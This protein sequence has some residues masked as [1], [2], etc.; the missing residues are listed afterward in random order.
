MAAFD[1]PNQN[2]RISPT[3][4]YQQQNYANALSTLTRGLGGATGVSPRPLTEKQQQQLVEQQNKRNAAQAVINDSALLEKVNKLQSLPA[5]EA[6]STLQDIRR[7][8]I[9]RISEATGVDSSELY[10]AMLGPIQ[11]QVNSRYRAVA[12]DRGSLSSIVAGARMGINEM[13]GAFRALSKN[14]E[15]A[16]AIGREVHQENEA[17]RESSPYWQDQMLRDQAGELVTFTGDT[18]SVTSNIARMLP[19]MAGQIGGTVAGAVTGG[20]VGG[21]V[22][23]FVGGTAA[24]STLGAI[25]GSQEFINRV[26]NDPRLT[27]EQKAEAIRTKRIPSAV[28]AGVFNA[29]PIN[30]NPVSQGLLR[31]ASGNIIGR[32][33]NRL[34]QNVGGRIVGNT[35]L[36]GA[37]LSLANAG[38]VLSRN[39]I[40]EQATGIDTPL[41]EGL[42]Q[43]LVQGA[44]MAPFFGAARTRVRNLGIPVTEAAAPTAPTADAARTI[45]NT[46]NTRSANDATSSSGSTFRDARSPEMVSFDRSVRSGYREGIKNE[47]ITDPQ[48]IYDSYVRDGRTAEDF[49]RFLDAD[50]IATDPLGSEIVTRL[51]KLIPDESTTRALPTEAVD[52]ITNIKQRVLRGEDFTMDQVNN[53]FAGDRGNGNTFVDAI[54]STLQDSYTTR[55][56]L[57]NQLHSTISRLGRSNSGNDPIARVISALDTY[58]ESGG[59]DGA[60]ARYMVDAAKSTQERGTVLSPAPGKLTKAQQSLLQEAVNRRARRNQESSNDAGNGIPD[61]GRNDGQRTTSVDPASVNQNSGVVPGTTADMGSTTGAAMPAVGGL[62]GATSSRG[63]GGAAQSDQRASQ[64]YAVPTETTGAGT[65]EGTNSGRRT[66]ATADA[67][68]TTGTR[69]GSA[70]SENGGTGGVAG[71]A[72]TTRSDNQSNNGGLSDLARRFDINVETLG[73]VVEETGVIPRDINAD[74]VPFITQVPEGP[75]VIRLPDSKTATKIDNTLID[76]VRKTPLDIAQ[77]L[78]TYY[79]TGGSDMQLNALLSS[80]KLSTKDRLRISKAMERVQTVERPSVNTNTVREALE[81]LPAGKIRS[82]DAAMSN[83][84]REAIGEKLT[85]AQQKQLKSLHDA[86]VPELVLPENIVQETAEARKLGMDTTPDGLVKAKANINETIQKITKQI[87]CRAI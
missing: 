6:R 82:V 18:G 59:N 37:E 72:A 5:A 35:L 57:T 16:R 42:G 74:A 55:N 50:T 70:G 49:R 53:S 34:G 79:K 9:R 23:A 73:R 48:T 29:I 62:D 33:A 76:S 26:E 81:A 10:T 30:A 56:T 40:Y 83:L 46:P 47:S 58:Y 67:D 84:I 2:V 19:Q 36:S 14:D 86:G 71:D 28:T 77:H 39:A 80:G 52:F 7:N 12:Q 61:V 43:A 51:R 11:E 3:W 44:G 78:D 75:K 66:G 24:A 45:P 65:G 41:T 54:Q 21:P 38:D 22:G 60:L 32:A 31:A 63:V 1:V 13:V 8:D 64:A 85:A 4:D 25:Q 68:A 20:L 69:T 27:E 17:I 87:L 15:E